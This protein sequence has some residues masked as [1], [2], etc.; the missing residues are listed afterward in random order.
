MCDVYCSMV[1]KV[2]ACFHLKTQTSTSNIVSVTV[3]LKLRQ[4]K[5]YRLL[6]WMKFPLK[7]LVLMEVTIEQ[8]ER[9]LKYLK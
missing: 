3:K 7:K 2:S 9:R 4:V 1:I 5:I 6:E 8:E